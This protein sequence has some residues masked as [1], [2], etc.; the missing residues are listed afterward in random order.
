IGSNPGIIVEAPSEGIIGDTRLSSVERARTYA[1]A[2]TFF[3]TAALGVGV[4]YSVA[5]GDRFDEDGY[6]PSVDWHF[7]RNIAAGVGIVR[8]SREGPIGDLE[9]LDHASLR[10][11]AR[12]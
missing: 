8:T 11:S 9:D 3:P 7:L 6:N 10:I 5:D 2:A 12:F 1:L 4:G